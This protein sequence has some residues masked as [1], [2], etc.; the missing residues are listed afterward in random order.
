[1]VVGNP[2]KRSMSLRAQTD[3]NEFKAAEEM[4]TFKYTNFQRIIAVHKSI[5]NV[6]GSLEGIGTQERDLFIKFLK[7]EDLSTVVCRQE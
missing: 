1:M 2:D 4:E 5:E 6:N 3:W 7:W